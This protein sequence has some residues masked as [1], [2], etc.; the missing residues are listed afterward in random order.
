LLIFLFFPPIAEEWEKLYQPVPLTQQIEETKR[1]VEQRRLDRIAREKIITECM[2]KM[3]SQ[4]K[5]WRARV[6]SKNVQAE[7][8]RMRREQVS[9]L[10]FFPRIRIFMDMCI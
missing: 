2:E 9:Y 3:D 8:E 10:Q 7:S 4:M 5:Q 1:A 6:S